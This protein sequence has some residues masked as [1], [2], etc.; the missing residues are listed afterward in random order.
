M[1]KQTAI[2][3]GILSVLVGYTLFN[4][5]GGELFTQGISMIAKK[6][7]PD[8]IQFLKDLESFSSKIGRAH[9]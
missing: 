4:R 6:I 7:S 9:V 8:G 1:T 5:R 2:L 3:L